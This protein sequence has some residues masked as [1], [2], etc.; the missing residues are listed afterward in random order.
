VGDRWASRQTLTDGHVSV[1]DQ[2]LATTANEVGALETSVENAET[3]DVGSPA[4]K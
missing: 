3:T 2:F 4:P 1:V